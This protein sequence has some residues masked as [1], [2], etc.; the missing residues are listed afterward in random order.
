[1]RDVKFRFWDD[2]NNKFWYGGQEGESEENKTF[3]SYFKDGGL[4]GAL[5]EPVSYGISQTGVDDYQEHRLIASQFTGL[6]DKSGKEI[7]EGDVVKRADDT[8]FRMEN[9]EIKFC[10]WL[11]EFKYAQWVFIDTPVSPATSYPAFYSNAKYMEIIGNIYE[12]PE[13]LEGEHK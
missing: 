5:V 11:V 8:P 13:L 4:V 9:G 6:K 10:T 2:L 3:Q 7:Y 1:M 12:N